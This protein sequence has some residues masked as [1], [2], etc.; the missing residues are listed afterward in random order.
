MTG[1]QKK[2]AAWFIASVEL[3]LGALVKILSTT[4]E[5][6]KWV[7]FG[8]EILMPAFAIIAATFPIS[9]NRPDGTTEPLPLP[10]IA[11]KE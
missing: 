10:P 7:H 5:A 3:I 8:A 6:G 11:K 2:F 1:N 4:S 9:I